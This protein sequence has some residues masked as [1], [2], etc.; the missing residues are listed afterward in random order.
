MRVRA[1]RGRL[2]HALFNLIDNAC[3]ATPT[4]GI[5]EVAI[6]AGDDVA[7]IEICDRGPG[8]PGAG[9]RAAAL[10]IAPDP[11]GCGGSGL[12]LIATRRFMESF[13][14][15]LEFMPREGGGSRCR[16]RLRRDAATAAATPELV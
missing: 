7:W 2:V 12:G 6:G 13:G 1:H 3:R 14:A 10:R 16:V 11:R 4:G 8:P 9:V 5:V 15:D